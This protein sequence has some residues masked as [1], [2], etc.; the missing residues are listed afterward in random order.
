VNKKI[1]FGII[2]LGVLAVTSWIF[3]FGFTLTPDIRLPGADNRTVELRMNVAIKTGDYRECSKLEG[4]ITQDYMSQCYEYF[5][6]RSKDPELCE[7]WQIKASSNLYCHKE[8]ALKLNDEKIC[9]KAE[10]DLDSTG[11]PWNECW[12]AMAVKKRNET[13]CEKILPKIDKDHTEIMPYVVGTCYAGVAKEKNDPSVCSEAKS[14]L[15]KMECINH[16]SQNQP[17][18]QD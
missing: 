8:M 4:N 7:F 15:I 3:L 2:T 17:G 14:D 9:E 10:V 12:R 18:S 1:I 5:I 13:L 11:S 16:L 6:D